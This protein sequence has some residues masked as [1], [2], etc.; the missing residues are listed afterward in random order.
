MAVRPVVR[1]LV[2]TARTR[3]VGTAVRETVPQVVYSR[4]LD[5]VIAKPLDAEELGAGAPAARGL[6][7]DP[8]DRRHE[9]DLRRLWRDEHPDDA[10]R[11]PPV[12]ANFDKGYRGF[13]IRR[14]QE[15][16]GYFWWVDGRTAARH[17]DPATFHIDLRDD[18]VYGFSYFIARDHRGGGVAM[19][20]LRAIEAELARL[21]YRRMW[22]F[23]D[24]ANTP[25]RWLYS[26]DGWSV[27]HTVRRERVLALHR[28]VVV[29]GA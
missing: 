1:D 12:L 11:T 21:G 28:N 25:A 16:I 14:E 10:S 9:P 5:L 20:G 29:D 22:G 8:L 23:V 2:R 19:D 13:L 15:A 18:D 7:I 17:P 3:G 27:S 24:F 6:V 4:E 26:V